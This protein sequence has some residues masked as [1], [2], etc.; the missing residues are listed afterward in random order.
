MLG[1]L[2]GL[3]IVKMEY[4]IKVVVSRCAIDGWLGRY[5]R[6]LLAVV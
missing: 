5:E 6:W 4:A 1:D 3:R 2:A